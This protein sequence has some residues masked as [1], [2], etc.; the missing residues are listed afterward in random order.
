MEPVE[1]V[2]AVTY[3]CNARCVMCGIWK[4]K[5]PPEAPPE[6]YR[7][8]PD[9]LRSVNVTG[10]EPFLR[11]D[12]EEVIGTVREACPRAEI[13]VSTNG[14]L[15]KRV[16]DVMRRVDD[17]KVGVAVSVDGIGEMH[18]RIRGVPESFVKTQQ[19]LRRLAEQGI[20]GV[21][22]AFT[23]TPENL[24]HFERVYD[25]SRQL[26]VEFTCAIAQ[27]SEHYFQ[28][29][30][31]GLRPAPEAL[32]RAMEP[33]ARAELATGSPKRWARAW[34]MR[35]LVRFATGQGRELACRAGRDFFFVDPAGEVYPCNVLC[36]IL[37]NLNEQSFEELWTSERAESARSEVERCH[38]GCWMICTARPAMRRR[39]CR[40]LAWALWKKL[41]GGPVI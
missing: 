41:F 6:M 37:G 22:I 10:G 7:K 4:G 18:D 9:S 38:T 17:G 26:G 40:I 21:R 8:L 31:E 29:G 19:T 5:Q 13:V 32:R 11:G 12:I 27:G 24:D 1:A 34:F 2:L 35:G 28:I 23:V 25:L 36:R 39:R 14:L 33:V 15:T 30:D 20:G 3:R 16:V